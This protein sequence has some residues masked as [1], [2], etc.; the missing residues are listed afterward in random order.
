MGLSFLG[1]VHRCSLCIIPFIAPN[2]KS[3]Y[4]RRSEALKPVWRSSSRIIRPLPLVCMRI[5]Q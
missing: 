5:K 4:E 2:P 1:Y 3:Q